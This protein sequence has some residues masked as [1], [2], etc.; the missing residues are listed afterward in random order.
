MHESSSIL[1]SPAAEIEAAMVDVVS[2]LELPRVCE[3]GTGD[4]DAVSAGVT[5]RG[6]SEIELVVSAPRSAARSVAAAFFGCDAGAVDGVDLNDAM[7]ELAN[8]CGGAIKP[9]LEG[10]WVIGVPDRDN[11]ARASVQGIFRARVPI[12]DKHAIVTVASSLGAQAEPGDG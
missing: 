11:P 9:L 3:S 7:G 6:D 1:N 5:L 12:G 8:I 4:E 2:A 10:Q